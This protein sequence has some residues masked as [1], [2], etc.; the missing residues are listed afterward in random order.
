MSAVTAAL[1]IAHTQVWEDGAA[2]SNNTELLRAV[3]RARE[4]AFFPRAQPRTGF[5]S[6]V[7]DY[8]APRRR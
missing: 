8:A 4:G 1:H 7:A 3:T 5:S 2:F 6:H